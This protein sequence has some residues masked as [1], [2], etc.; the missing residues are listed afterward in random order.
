MTQKEL[1]QRYGKTYNLTPADWAK[2]A[3]ESKRTGYSVQQL[4]ELRR[5][6]ARDAV[7][8]EVSYS[9]STRAEQKAH[10]NQ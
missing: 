8:D 9:Q 3:R 1:V 4:L 10:D 6:A 5:D 7:A 2:L